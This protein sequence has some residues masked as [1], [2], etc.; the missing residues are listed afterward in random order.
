MIGRDTENETGSCSSGESERERQRGDK[1]HKQRYRKLRLSWGLCRV[2][3]EKWDNLGW[4]SHFPY[5]SLQAFSLYVL[6]LLRCN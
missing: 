1:R 6:S 3:E 5:L 2:N 4:S